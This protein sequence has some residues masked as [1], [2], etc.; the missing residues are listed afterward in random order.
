MVKMRL[1]KAVMNIIS[2]KV[3]VEW[4]EGLESG[5]HDWGDGVSK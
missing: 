5:A 4:G 1:G 3:K 2:S